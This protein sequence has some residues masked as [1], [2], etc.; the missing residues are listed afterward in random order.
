MFWHG[1]IKTNQ[2]D[3]NLNSVC[4]RKSQIFLEYED[5]YEIN[6]RQLNYSF[7]FYHLSCVACRK[8]TSAD[9]VFLVETSSRIGQENFQKMKDFLYT[10]VSSLD[11][12]NDQVRVGL[13]QYSHEPYKVFLLNQY[14]LKSDIL[15]QIKNLPNRSGGTYTG[16]ALDFIRTEY[17]TRAAGSRAE[18]NVPQ[19]V[20]LVSVGES[21]DEVRTQAKE[22]K[23]RGISLY[24]VGIN[25]RDPTELKK[26]SSRPF[27]KFLFRTDSFDGLQDLSTS[28]LQTMCFAIESQIQGK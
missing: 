2:L 21:N 7:T 5:S 8:A 6:E 11:V 3:N 10:L 28:L 27:K 23:V 25:D 19:V 22:L 26:I 18:E 16:T 9:I 13:A 14:S 12:G 4:R 1:C 17:F 15:E 24:V 20:I